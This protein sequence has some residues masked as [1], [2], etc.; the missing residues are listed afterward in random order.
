[1]NWKGLP[2]P[3][4]EEAVALLVASRL[5]AVVIFQFIIVSLVLVFSNVLAAEGLFEF[6]WVLSDQKLLRLFI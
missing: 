4:K 1:L 5:D 6:S 2:L 3:D